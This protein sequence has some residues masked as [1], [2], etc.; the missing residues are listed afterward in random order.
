MSKSY[1]GFQE[2]KFFGYIVRK[3]SFELGE[4]RKTAIARIPFPRSV[5]EM[6]S[7]LGLCIFFQRFV[8]HYASKVAQLYDMTK[9]NFNWD[10]TSWKVDYH[11]VFKDAKQAI[12]DSM[13]LY[14]PDYNLRWIVRTDA[15]KFGVGGALFQIKVEEDGS[16]ILQILA[17]VSKKFSD[18][19]VNWAI[20]Q[21]ECYGIYFT[22][23]TLQYY[24]RGKFFELET[25]HANLQWMEASDNPLIIRMRVF[26]QG[27]VTV[28][29]HIPGS[30]N[31][32]ADFLSRTELQGTAEQNNLSNILYRDELLEFYSLFDSCFPE[33]EAQCK[34]QE[35]FF[36]IQSSIFS[37]IVNE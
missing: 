25:D 24:L 27:L 4:E 8:P 31:K 23:H 34:A 5:K 11:T 29:R 33:D 2:V 12:I 30:Q 21:Q 28:I 20:I 3:D 36:M 16:Q 32:I 22:L 1:L 37:E 7:F 14:F 10:V 6:Q 19:A 9:Q 15:S 13:K 26:V 18:R 17:M 35:F